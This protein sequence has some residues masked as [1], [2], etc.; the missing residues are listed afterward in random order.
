MTSLKQVGC[1]R[2][3][4]GERV[5]GVKKNCELVHHVQ[6]CNMSTSLCGIFDLDTFI[7]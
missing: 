4:E 2:V 3:K 5:F 1:L 6:A 7:H